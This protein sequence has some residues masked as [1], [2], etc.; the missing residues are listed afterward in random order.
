MYV[1][2]L[3]NYSKAFHKQHD[4]NVNMCSLQFCLNHDDIT[5]QTPSW[6]MQ[7]MQQER[8]HMEQN[9]VSW[10]GV[11]LQLFCF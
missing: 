10:E 6:V 11:E 7:L 4:V 2:L 1:Q 5:L 9:G 8:S 3:Q